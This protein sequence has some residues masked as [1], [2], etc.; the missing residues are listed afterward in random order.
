MN[1]E[2]RETLDRR[3]TTHTEEIKELS[4]VVQN[5]ILDAVDSLK[6]Q[7]L[8]K[9]KAVYDLDQTIN[10]KRYEIE[11]DALATVATQQPMASDLR[12]LSSI[13]DLAGELERIGDYAKGIA[14]ITMRI[15]DQPLLMKMDSVSEMAQLTA[16]MLNRSIKAFIDL[17][18]E[19]A[20][21]IADEDDQI[22]L[23]YNKLYK[24]LLDLMIKDRKNIDQATFLL[25]V[26][27]NLERAA[28]R[29]TNICER[30]VFTTS[31]DLVEFDRSDDE[32]EAF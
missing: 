28:D 22:D 26:S 3:I 31:G 27:H 4:G 1:R 32:V 25:W 6:N 8:I 21:G 5:S 16:E 12:K 20:L 29:V 19:T 30:V 15:G 17:D 7:D 9:A 11:S 2:L 23:M 18:E 10:K 13:I 24:E 14:R